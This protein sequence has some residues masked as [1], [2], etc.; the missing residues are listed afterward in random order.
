MRKTVYAKPLRGEHGFTLIE[1]LIALA[2]LAVILTV[3]Y[4]SYATSVEVMQQVQER[5]ATYQ[6]VRIITELLS[7]QLSSAMLASDQRSVFLGEDETIGDFPA[8]RL[9]FTAPTT[10]LLSLNQPQGGLCTIR[11]FLQPFREESIRK[12]LLRQEICPLVLLEE[13]STDK[14]ITLEL[15]SDVVGWDLK[16]YTG[17]EEFDSWEAQGSGSSAG[18]LPQRVKVTLLLLTEKQE[19]AGET[20]PQAFTTLIA[21]PLASQ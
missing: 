4:T 3:L 5:T 2:I 15:S 18:R 19:Q 7:Q 6:S 13:E 20:T 10:T 8:D 14:G 16:Y 21:L 1:V 11:Y 9:T 17:E 12:S